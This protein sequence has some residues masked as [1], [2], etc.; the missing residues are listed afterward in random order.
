[1]SPDF[2]IRNSFYTGLWF[3]W[4]PSTAFL[5]YKP[6][7][8]WYQR[9][10]KIFL[11]QLI[12]LQLL[13]NEIDALFLKLNQNVTTNCHLIYADCTSNCVK[14]NLKYKLRKIDDNLIVIFWFIW[15]NNESISLKITFASMESFDPV[16]L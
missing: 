2:S 6:S 12:I 5:E 16:L 14:N 9:K 10:L 11:F 8:L 3:F 1:M 7:I 13:F 4:L 15:N